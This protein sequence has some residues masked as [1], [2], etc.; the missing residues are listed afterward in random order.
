MTGYLCQ[1]GAGVEGRSPISGRTGGRISGRTNLA[2]RLLCAGVLMSLAA[3]GSASAALVYDL[4]YADPAGTPTGSAPYAR[5]VV[6]EVPVGPVAGVRFT[7]TSLVGGHHVSSFY[8]N[9]AGPSDASDLRLDSITQGRVTRTAFMEPADPAGPFGTFDRQISP[10]YQTGPGGYDVHTWSFTL[11]AQENGSDVSSLPSDYVSPSA[12][13][14][15]PGAP[16]G[17]SV[18]FAAGLNSFTGGF[19]VGGPAPTAGVPEPTALGLIT[20]AAAGSLARW[21]R[22]GG[23]K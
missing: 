9:T 1:R 23:V 12:G 3:T 14:F 5:V 13:P 15:P 21:R 8:F 6:E 20:L 22:P 2:T 19:Y 7:V 16:G 18:Y 4:E 17:G 10:A 11:V